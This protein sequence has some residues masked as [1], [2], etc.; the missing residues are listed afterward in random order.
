MTTVMIAI[1]KAIPPAA[2]LP[3]MIGKSFFESK[4]SRYIYT[5]NYKFHILFLFWFTISTNKLF[6][7]VCSE[8]HWTSAKKPQQ[9]S[10]F[11]NNIAKNTANKLIN[12]NKISVS[13][14][15]NIMFF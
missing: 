1:A 13:P 4:T 3:A 8:I 12:S 9:Y 14:T 2:A 11:E 6:H 15:F 5:H 10:Y 7:K